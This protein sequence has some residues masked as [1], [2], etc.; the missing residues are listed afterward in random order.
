MRYDKNTEQTI[1]TP[2]AEFINGDWQNVTVLPL[3]VGFARADAGTDDAVW[4]T[5]A[6]HT[7]IARDPDVY[8]VITK[9][10]PGET[11]TLDEGRWMHYISLDG[12]VF[13]VGLIEVY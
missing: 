4:A 11:I 6:W 5:G 12:E 3:Q 7:E 2:V 13:E 8:V 9:F 10:G 1:Y